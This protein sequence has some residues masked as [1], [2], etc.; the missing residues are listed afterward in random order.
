MNITGQEDRQKLVAWAE[1]GLRFLQSERHKVQIQT[2]QQEIARLKEGRFVIAVMGKAKR[3]KSTLLNALLGRRDDLLAPIDKLPASSAITRFRW[4]PREEVTVVLRDGRKETIPASQVRDY[5][6]EE[7]NPENRKGV[8]VVEV[9]APF[10]DFDRDL[11]L[12]D[13]PGAGSL[14]EHHGAILQGIIPQADAVIFL[15][16]TRM[17]LDQD[18]VELLGSMKAADVR[19]VFFAVNKV[20]EVVNPKDLDDALAHNR[21]LLTQ[22]GVS[23]GTMFPISARQAYQG[24]LA[25]SGLVPMTNMI[26]SEIASQKALLLSQRFIAGV[27]AA[28]TS[29]HQAAALELE[30]FKKTQAELEQEARRLE[31]EKAE[32]D[33]KR[34]LVESAFT[35]AWGMAVDDFERSLNDSSDSVQRQVR[36][37]I[38]ETSNLALS[39]LGKDLSGFL[40]TKFEAELAGPAERFE[41]AVR[42]AC[43]QL[44]AEYPKLALGGTNDVS[45]TVREDRKPLLRAGVVSGL[46]LLAPGVAASLAG[47]V[48]LIGPLLAGLVF[49]AAAPAALLV[50]GIAGLNLAFGY[51]ASKLRLREDMME[52]AR[53]QVKECFDVLR[54]RRIPDLRRTGTQILDQYR[55]RLAHRIADCELAIGNAKERS[56]DPNEE[57]QLLRE[58]ESLRQF[59]SN[60]P[61]GF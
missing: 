10:L 60:L 51:K 53:K 24:D 1:T 58:E 5:V 18:E 34:P 33:R 61:Q 19:R 49:T 35:L 28:M 6:T 3:G 20:D 9:A 41:I 52:A 59:L 7:G 26:R 48:P 31:K 30:A 40:T 43:Q 17:P 16:T 14:H 21:S 54:A 44:D 50:A 46:A 45:V 4:A 32:C 2:I 29:A 12:M 37:R 36:Q 13:T 25:G 55:H 8:D 15:V 47:T 11:V 39:A 22:I 42:A 38:E 23:V 56:K 27:Q 57:A